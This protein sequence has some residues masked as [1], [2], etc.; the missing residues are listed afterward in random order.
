MN[1]LRVTFSRNMLAEH[2]FFNYQF[3]PLMMGFLVLVPSTLITP[4]NP[5]TSSTPISPGTPKPK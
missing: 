3:Q 5:G 4:S 2:L 1:S